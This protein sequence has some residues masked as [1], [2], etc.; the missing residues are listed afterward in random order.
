[1]S[2]NRSEPTSKSLTEDDAVLIWRLRSAGESQHR[3]AARL[4]VNPGR[5]CEVLKGRRF[6]GARGI[7]EGDNEDGDEG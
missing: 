6:P 2:V 5:V 3:I 7:A 1:M 4:D